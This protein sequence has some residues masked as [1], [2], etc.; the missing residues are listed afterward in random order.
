MNNKKYKVLFFSALCLFLASL[1]VLIIYLYPHLKSP[2]KKDIVPTKNESSASSEKP[3]PDNPKNFAELQKKS[4]DIYAWI[5]IPGTRVD[6]PVLQSGDNHPENFYLNHDVNGK[7]LFAGSIY[8]QRYNSTDFSD[9]NTVLYGHNMK[10]GS[11]FATL[12]KFRD[13]K[14]FD[15]NKDIYIYTPGHILTYK[16]YAAY[17]YDNRHL[18][19]SF[20]L[21]DPIIFEEYLK[22]TQ[23]PNSLIM[24]I[25]K[26]VELTTDDK[27]LTLSTCITN[28]NYR[29]LVQGVL[30]SDQ[31]TK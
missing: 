8:S 3:L 20:D 7:Y 4:P 28:D 1:T 9:P 26:S 19:M 10:N 22:I 5:E 14:F 31:P 12:H 18:L 15:E 30:V 29:Y 13:K 27:I 16:I 17:R 2:N 23:N 21:N 25:D 6:Y 11:M 24:N